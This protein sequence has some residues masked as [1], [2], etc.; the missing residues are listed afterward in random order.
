VNE[1]QARKAGEGLGAGSACQ[2]RKAPLVLI[3]QAG[4]PATY[5]SNMSSSSST[6]EHRHCA[7]AGSSQKSEVG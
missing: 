7:P 1:G 5:P 3:R 6:A 2:C 4:F